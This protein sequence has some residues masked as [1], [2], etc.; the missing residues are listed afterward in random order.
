MDARRRTLLALATALLLAPAGRAGELLRETYRD[1]G[2]HFTLTLPSGWAVVSPSGLETMNGAAN[3]M[4]GGVRFDAAFMVKGQPLGSY[5]Y[6]L[7]Q[8]MPRNTSGLTYEQIERELSRDFS[9]EVKK[10]EGKLADVAR[11]LSLGKPAL[12]RG[13]NRVL[14]RVQMD[15]ALFGKVNGLSVGMLGKDGVTFVHCY[16]KDADFDRQMPTFN[17]LA[18]SFHYDAGYEFVPGKPGSLSFDLNGALGGGARGGIIGG[19]AGGIV[20]LSFA[21]RRAGRRQAF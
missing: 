19:T 1:A 5:P 21:L 12:D 3:R 17:A 14:N 6:V 2:R 18:D 10:V 4:M 9:G 13:K 8:S 20:A 11:N 15:V 16:A 7:V